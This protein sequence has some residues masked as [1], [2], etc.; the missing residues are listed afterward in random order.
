ME[1]G[2]SGVAVNEVLGKMD[3]GEKSSEETRQAMSLFG[4]NLQH[5]ILFSTQNY[6]RMNIN[7]HKE[8]PYKIIGP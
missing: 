4:N 8:L 7:Q 1:R 6:L 5:G 2:L 3:G